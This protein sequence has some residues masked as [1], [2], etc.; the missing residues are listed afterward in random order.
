MFAGHETTA[1][2]LTWLYKLLEGHDDITDNLREEARATLQGGVPTLP[3]LGRLTYTRQVIDEVLRLRPA[4]PVIAR[5]AND[6]DI[7]G[8]TVVQAGDV[9]MSYAVA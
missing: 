6:A 9:A 2:T 1:L 5:V 3:D 8:G 4:G 7:L